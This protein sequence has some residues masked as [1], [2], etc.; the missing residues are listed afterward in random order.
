VSL[1]LLA[2]P[3]ANPPYWIIRNTWGT[4][5]GVD[6]YV[7]IAMNKNLCGKCPS[8]MGNLTTAENLLYNLTFGLTLI[9]LSMNCS[10]IFVVIPSII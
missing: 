3:T 8:K 2:L 5:W 4:D 10:Y 7:F 9:L 6:G 1:P